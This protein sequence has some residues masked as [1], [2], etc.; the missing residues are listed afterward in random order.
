MP[1]KGPRGQFAPRC[2]PRVDLF[3]VNHF[4]DG[5]N[6][7]PRIRSNVWARCIWGDADVLHIR[8]NDIEVNVIV[9]W[10]HFRGK[11]K[12]RPF[13]RKGSARDLSPC[14]LPWLHLLCQ[15][16]RVTGNNLSASVFSTAFD[17]HTRLIIDG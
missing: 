1:S 6:R 15:F 10:P 7:S 9:A 4:A 2:L 16:H 11:T 3:A 8:R 5:Q 13:T 17:V 12:I 14:P